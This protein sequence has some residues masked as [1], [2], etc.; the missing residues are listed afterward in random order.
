MDRDWLAARL[1]AGD[2]M[3]A[4]AREVGR[5]PSTVSYWVNRHGLT[6]VHADRH[7]T[8]GGI[9]RDVLEPLVVC[10]MSIRQIAR[11]LDR[12]PATVRHWL[13][14]YELKTVTAQRV[15]RDGSTEPEVIRDCPRHG[16][17]TF[18]HVGAQ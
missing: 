9:P 8:R 6:S 12:S 17:T 4:I 16:W 1:E 5:H 13:R 18:R 11:E 3:E 7:A 2:S 14:R 15:R 10:G